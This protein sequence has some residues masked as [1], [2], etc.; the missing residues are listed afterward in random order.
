MEFRLSEEHPQ[1]RHLACTFA[2]CES[3]AS[4]HK[5]GRQHVMT[6]TLLPEMAFTSILGVF[7]SPFTP[8]PGIAR[9]ERLTRFTP[10]YVG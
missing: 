6:H 3:V 10:A 5:F 9:V 7:I 4:S 1:L 2:E 8:R